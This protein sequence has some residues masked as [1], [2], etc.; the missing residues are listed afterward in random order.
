M[1][2]PRALVIHQNTIFVADG[3]NHRV[4]AIDRNG[5]FL[6][7]IGGN[8]TGNANGKFNQPYGRSFQ[9]RQTNCML[10]IGITTGFRFWLQGNFIAH[11]DP[12]NLEG[13][14]N[15]PVDLELNDDE[16]RRSQSW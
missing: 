11:L 14:F 1:N 9:R 7:N 3:A 12:G 6:F 8:V 5:T 10:R 4:V 13:Q 16:P 2:D 15:H